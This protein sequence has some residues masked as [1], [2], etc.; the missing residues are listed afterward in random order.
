MHEISTELHKLNIVNLGIVDYREAHQLQ[1]RLLQE[2]IEG[3]GSD[4]LV[5]LQHNPVI[6]IGRSGSKSN[7]LLS[8]SALAAAG[9]EVC[10]I[11]RGGDVTYHGPGQLTGYPIIN[12][13]HFRKDVHWYLRQLEEVI[14]RVLTEYGIT[15]E[16]IEGYTG[17]WVGNEKIAAIGI[18]VRR[19]ITY[20][21][22][23]FNINPDMSHFQMITP[24]G[25]TDKGVTSLERLLGYRVDID[26][27]A[28][29]TASAFARVLSVVQVHK[30]EIQND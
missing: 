28:D 21:G 4:T 23:A 25:I 9:I 27:V 10:E 13:Q 18:S 15:G 11:E 24:C 5:L 7:I 6:T 19:W 3:R 17:V 20:H 1:K 26:E 14:I 12:L 29:R 2:H 22:F 16:R 30:S 8:E